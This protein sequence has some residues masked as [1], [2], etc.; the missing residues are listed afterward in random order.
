[1][2]DPYDYLF[3]FLV[4]GSAGTGKSCLLHQFIE[5][6]FKDESSH[7]IG[8]KITTKIAFESF[9]NHSVQTN[10]VILRLFLFIECYLSERVFSYRNLIFPLNADSVANRPKFLPQNANV[11]PEKAQRP[12]KSAAELSAG[13]PKKWQKRGRT[14]LKCG[15][16]IKS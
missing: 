10:N 15:F 14:F 13:L 8:K 12:R 9:S 6:R 16:H 3:K 7:T 1:M 4:I 11:A 5:N 2:N